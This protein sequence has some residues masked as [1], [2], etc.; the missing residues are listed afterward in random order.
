MSIDLTQAE[1]NELMAM[2]KRASTTGIQQFPSVGG[3]LV[4]E[5]ESVDKSEDF[6]LDV[7]RSRID[8]SRITYQNRGRV[9]VVLRRLDLNGAPHRNPDDQIIPCPHLHTYREGYGDKWAEP[10]PNGKFTNLGNMSLT[11]AEF[12]AE[13]N[14][15]EAP[16]IQAGLF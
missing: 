9:V 13:C 10:V 4:I 8:F 3:K 5:L 12:M 7:T 1:A 11:L 6:L 16:M 14:V 15:V 2:P